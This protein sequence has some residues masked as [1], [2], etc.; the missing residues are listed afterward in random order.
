MPRALLASSL[1]RYHLDL[2]PQGVRDGGDGL[3]LGVDVGS[4][5]RRTLDGSF[6]IARASSAFDIPACSRSQ[7]R[8][9]GY[10]YALSFSNSNPCTGRTRA[11]QTHQTGSLAGTPSCRRD[12]HP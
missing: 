6:P 5:N 12:P 2:R 10:V 9:G 3:Q 8:R 1:A 7:A 4:K 11:D